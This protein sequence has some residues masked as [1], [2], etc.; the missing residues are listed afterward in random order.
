M[1]EWFYVRSGKVI[2]AR[3]RSMHGLDYTARCGTTPA[4]FEDWLGTGNQKEY[5][6]VASLP[7]CKRCVKLLGASRRVS[8]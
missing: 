8:R 5:E 6:T 2:H 3:S 7:K 1:I 4:L